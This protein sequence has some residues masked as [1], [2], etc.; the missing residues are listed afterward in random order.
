MTA[1]SSPAEQRVVLEN[2]SWA[3]YLRILEDADNR[4]GRIAYD[5]GILEIMSPSKLHETIKKLIGRMIEAFTEELN[6]EIASVSSATFKRA[7]LQRGFEADECYYIQNAAAIR[8][9]DE[10]DLA[11]DPPPDLAIEIDI[12]RSAM[13]K[14]GIFGALGVPEVWRYDGR[15]ILVYL[16]Q[17]SGDYAQVEQSAALPQLPISEVARF[18]E[19]RGSLGETQLIRSFRSRARDRFA[20]GS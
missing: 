2:I 17:E 14:F 19:Q 1:V 6:I 20:G 4:R 16:R 5:R 15:T 8:G 11:V 7:D 10:I 3:T 13:D 18:L 9:R 12:S